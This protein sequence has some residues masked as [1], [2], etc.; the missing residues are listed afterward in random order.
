MKTPE[1][2][3]S[4]RKDHM[5][6]FSLDEKLRGRFRDLKASIRKHCAAGTMI[7]AAFSLATAGIIG[8][9]LGPGFPS[10]TQ[11]QGDDEYTTFTV[12]ITQDGDTN[13]QFFMNPAGAPDLFSRG[14]VF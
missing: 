8:V 3:S 13:A 4:A 7:L 12:D 14:D 5:N 6:G 2:S 1:G 10:V 11:A 9:S